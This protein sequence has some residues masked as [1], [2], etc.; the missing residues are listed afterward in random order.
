MRRLYTPEDDELLRQWHNE[1]VSLVEQ[2]RRLGRTRGA[3]NWREAA[4]FVAKMNMLTGA[5][6]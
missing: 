1:G 2:A 6:V 3:I 5:A 4:R